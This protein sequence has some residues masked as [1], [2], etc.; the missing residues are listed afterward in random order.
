M[1]NAPYAIFKKNGLTSGLVSEGIRTTVWFFFKTRFIPCTRPFE[2][3]FATQPLQAPIRF[4]GKPLHIHP[5]N[6]GTPNGGVN[7]AVF[8]AGVFSLS[9]DIWYKMNTFDEIEEPVVLSPDGRKR[10]RTPENHKRA[11]SKQMRHS[12]GG[13]IP[14]SSCTH[15]SD[16]DTDERVWLYGRLIHDIAKTSAAL[17]FTLPMIQL[18]KMRLC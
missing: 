18:P 16:D 8:G 3:A 5:A 6:H 7:K 10:R 11:K 14:A 4:L 9:L 15:D 2:N 12:G 1:Q 17:N 13:K